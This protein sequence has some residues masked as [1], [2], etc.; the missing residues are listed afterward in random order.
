MVCMLGKNRGQDC[1]CSETACLTCGWEE[2]E[3]ERRKKLLEEN[4]L[5]KRPD[6]LLTLMIGGSENEDPE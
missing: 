5:Q 3:H 2:S 1:R 4:G 6:G